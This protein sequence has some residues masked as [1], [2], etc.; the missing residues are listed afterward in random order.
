MNEIA[1]AKKLLKD[2]GFYTDNLWHVDDVK[3]LLQDYQ[4][5]DEDALEILDKTLQSEWIMQQI[6]ESINEVCAGHSHVE[7]ID[8]DE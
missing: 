4:C 2:N 5:T 7:K 8:S 6:N 3:R 1:K